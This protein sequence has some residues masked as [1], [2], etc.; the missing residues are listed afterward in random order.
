[1]SEFH[2]FTKF[3][4]SVQKVFIISTSKFVH[5]KLEFHGI[6]LKTRNL[7]IVCT[8]YS[9]AREN[10]LRYRVQTFHLFGVSGLSR[11]LGLHGL[12]GL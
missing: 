3:G 1:M 2:K 10:S 5:L 11:L 8:K 4:I 7:F 12:S 9:F 6:K